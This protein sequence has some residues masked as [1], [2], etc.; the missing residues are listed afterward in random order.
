MSRA[1]VFILHSVDSR[2]VAAALAEAL[3]RL[4]IDP[5]V[6][7]EQI[8][9]GENLVEAI[10]SAMGRADAF[11]VLIWPGDLHRANVNFELGVA[12][13]LGK[14]VIPVLGPNVTAFRIPFDLAVRRQLLW[15]SAESVASEVA[16]ALEAQ[17]LPA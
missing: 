1:R 11:V 7:E 15:S 4:D 2:E 9:A 8:T 17:A 5:W 6:A 10:E 3:R 13:G 16:R 14:R 12:V